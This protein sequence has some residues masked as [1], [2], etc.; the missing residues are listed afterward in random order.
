[1]APLR[2]ALIGLWVAGALHAA[3]GVAAMPIAYGLFA[4]QA[5]VLFRRAG[6]FGPLVSIAY[7]LPLLA[8][9]ALFA[10]SAAHRLARRP[11][12]WRGRTVAP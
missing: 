7:P 6:R 4:I 12:A 10:G 8:F 1:M 9:V 3:L 11:V 5:A 2:A